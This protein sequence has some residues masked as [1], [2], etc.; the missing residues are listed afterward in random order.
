MK[1][2]DRKSLSAKMKMI[3][4]REDMDSD[5]DFKSRPPKAQSA[6]R[7]SQ[8]D[9][10]GGSGKSA[11][12]S[13]LFTKKKE[14]GNCSDQENQRSDSGDDEIPHASSQPVISPS[15]K[16]VIDLDS[17]LEGSVLSQSSDDDEEDDNGEEATGDEDQPPAGGRAAPRG[18]KS[19]VPL[20]TR[21]LEYIR[22]NQELYLHILQ[23]KPVNILTLH[24]ELRQTGLR[25]SQKK[26]GTFL[27]FQGC[28]YIVPKSEK[29][30]EKL[31]LKSQSRQAYFRK[32]FKGRGAH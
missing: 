3:I 18:K 1:D 2:S 27:D 28:T 16:V 12:L 13:Q 20:E 21:L 9:V 6:T 30:K 22:G 11:S 26:L 31:K 7:L 10:S 23:F 14:Q 32:K 4:D 5:D 24:E 17:D 15:K 8:Q 19:T 29:E 25:C